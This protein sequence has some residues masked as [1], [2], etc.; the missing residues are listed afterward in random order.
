[1]DATFSYIVVH[2]RNLLTLFALPWNSA[3]THHPFLTPVCQLEEVEACFIDLPC[4]AVAHFMVKIFHFQSS[5]AD[6][7]FTVFFHTSVVSQV[8]YIRSI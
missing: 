8:M 6:H 4:P 3:T 1:M 5:G 7:G 2:R